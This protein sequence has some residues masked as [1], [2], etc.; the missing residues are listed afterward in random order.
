MAG[1]CA[2]TTELID[3]GR[4]GAARAGLPATQ[5]VAGRQLIPEL[6]ELLT[7]SDLAIFIDAATETAPGEVVVTRPAGDVQPARL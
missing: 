3:C 1:S 4:I 5:V 6:V 2:A 7:Q